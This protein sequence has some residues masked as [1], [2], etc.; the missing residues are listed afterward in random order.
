MSIKIHHGAPGSYKTSGAVLDDFIPAVLAG[1]HVITNVRGLNDRN[2]IEDVLIKKGREVPSSFELTFL[3]TTDSAQMDMLR[4]WF[5]WAP[6]G[7]FFLIDEIQEVYPKS[8]T[9]AKLTE[10]DYPGGLDAATEAGTFETLALAF[11]KH[12]HK[13]WDFVV[14]TPHISKVHEVVRGSAEGAYKHRNLAVLGPMFKGRY[15]EAF[16]TA[17]NNGRQSDFYTIRRKRIPKYVFQ[18]YSST[19]T[20]QIS[21]TAAGGN[22]FTD[23][24][25]LF[26]VAILLG[27]GIYL[28]IADT[29]AI[30]TG[31]PDAAP[32]PDAQT[33]APADP[34]APPPPV[35][36]HPAP[37]GA[38]NA[39][40]GTVPA[41][42]VV[43]P[44][45]L[46][47]LKMAD[48]LFVINTFSVG[49]DQ[50]FSI[51]ADLKDNQY[52]FTQSVMRKIGL[53]SLF[54]DKC[55]VAIEYNDFTSYATC[56]PLDLLPK[57]PK[58][59]TI[60]DNPFTQKQKPGA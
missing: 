2:K 39:G 28:F 37:A 51:R 56:P 11:E 29:P 17:D 24:K 55:L 6:A 30:F 42:P 48:N 1:R 58:S 36:G 31:S 46:K 35:P 7:C 13:N 52:I 53:Q 59:T 41:P 43:D 12:R 5:H 32:V 27:V 54:Y 14:T 16:H 15:I 20:G 10:F 50:F 18:L 40:V 3:D 47:L 25:M 57:D 8:I 26:F 34:D 45:W 49:G 60:F 23:P 22:I 21:D 19:A 9:T 38:A 44:A 33:A 4:K